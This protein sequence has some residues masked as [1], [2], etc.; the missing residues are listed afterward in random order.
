MDENELSAE[1]MPPIGEGESVEGEEEDV[2]SLKKALAEEQARAEGYL[3]SW[4][5]AQADF[6]NFKRRTD[7]ERN[8]TVIRANAALMLNLLP[9]LDDLE[10]ALDNISEKLSRLTWVDGIVLIYRKLKSTLEANGLSEVKALGETFDPNF[11]EAALYDDGEEGKVIE[12]LQKGYMLHDRVLR[13]AMV[14][15]GRGLMEKEE[16]EEKSQEE[17]QEE[18]NG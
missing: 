8:E 7:Q 17:V 10:R 2:E 3:A 11:H 15:V 12:E 14:K 16:E 9:V 6:A 1:E 18:N 4:Q 13:P 5:R